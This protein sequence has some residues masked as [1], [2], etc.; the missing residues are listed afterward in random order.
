M[1]KIY[2]ITKLASTSRDVSFSTVRD[3]RNQSLA[4]IS[5]SLGIDRAVVATQGFLGL[6]PYRIRG[7]LLQEG[8]MLT[9]NINLFSSDNHLV[10]FRRK[11][12][13]DVF[14]GAQKIEGHVG[15]LLGSLAG[16]NGDIKLSITNDNTEINELLNQA[17]E[18]IV[19]HMDPYL[20]ARYYFVQ[21]SPKGV[22]T[23]TTPQLAR[24]LEVLPRNQ[25]TWPLLLWGR[26][27]HL[28]GEYDKAIALYQEIERL[29]PHFLFAPV[30]WGEALAALGRHQE[31]IA[32]YQKAIQ[33]KQFYNPSY[34]VARS[35]AHALWADSLIAMGRVDEAED[36]LNAGIRAFNLGNHNAEAT[37]ISH[38]ALGRFLMNHRQDYERAEDHLR[39]AVYLE[40]DP[41]FY[42]DLQESIA[43]RLPEY[44]IYLEK[45]R[46]QNRASE[47]AA[48]E[49]AHATD[50]PA[51]QTF[52]AQKPLVP[53]LKP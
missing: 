18:A 14:E 51:P 27:H 30:R 32:L 24:C 45:A 2:D 39:K 41:K 33:D 19:D 11:T 4:N 48:K 53:V 12:D 29:D 6:I 52:P 50:A 36:V 20:L 8:D 44:G 13:K 3:M 43:K 25:H 47:A 16:A 1:P 31:A 22:F 23:K 35:T 9:L 10:R 46:S 7:I 5:E 34:P 26:A 17:A 42:A 15:G 49:P 40:D 38:R 21:E 28:K 37:A